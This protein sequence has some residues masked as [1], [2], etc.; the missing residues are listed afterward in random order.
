MN[1]EAHD[2]IIDRYLNG[3]M[4]PSEE[5]DFF[6][7]ME[8]D[9]E[10]KAA[11]MAEQLIGQ[12]TRREKDAIGAAPAESYTHFLAAL[13]AVGAGA[14][15][16][17]AAGASAATSS[18]AATTAATTT[19]ATTATVTTTAAGGSFLGTL[20]ATGA[21]K[22]IIAAV[23]IAAVGTG[24]YMTSPL[25]DDAERRDNNPSAIERNI[26]DEATPATAPLVPPASDHRSESAV[27]ADV[28]TPQ[29]T[30]QQTTVQETPVLRAPDA[31]GSAGVPATMNGKAK[32]PVPAVSSEKTTTHESQKATDTRAWEREADDQ[33]IRVI[34]SDSIRTKFDGVK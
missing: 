25:G 22:A 16:A 15:T 28:T 2:R 30:P 26:T 29:V 9:E 20:L 3:E 13:A 10:L 21:A 19:A 34:V 14:A 1:S 4:T 12:T 24:V 27:P 5:R 8:L 32:Q 33:P 23:G 17:G 18:A 31:S 6:Q 11:F 7:L